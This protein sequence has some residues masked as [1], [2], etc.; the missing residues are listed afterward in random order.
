VRPRRNC[1]EPHKFPLWAVEL[2]NRVTDGRMRP[3]L[4]WV[5][6]DAKMRGWGYQ[7]CIFQTRSEFHCSGGKEEIDADMSYPDRCWLGDAKYAKN[8]SRS[9]KVRKSNGEYSQFWMHVDIRKQDEDEYTRYGII[10]KNPDA[11]GKPCWNIGLYTA[12]SHPALL[13]FYMEL[14]ESKDIEGMIEHVP[15]RNACKA[16]NEFGN[17]DPARPP[18][19]NPEDDWWNYDPSEYGDIA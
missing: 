4:P 19:I 12:I 13:P 15:M 17:D 1:C 10:T 18:R 11:P 5:D 6:R 9:P 2:P 3:D 14:Y 16:Q 7:Y 8:A